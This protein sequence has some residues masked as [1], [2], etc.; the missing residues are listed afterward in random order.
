L[1]VGS[2]NTLDGRNKQEETITDR[3]NLGKHLQNHFAPAR[4]AVH[5]KGDP[6]GGASSI[7]VACPQ[8]NS[9]IMR[10]FSVTS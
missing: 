8:V 4:Q 5:K 6:D 3:E 10:Y 2:E 7:R 1:V 9:D